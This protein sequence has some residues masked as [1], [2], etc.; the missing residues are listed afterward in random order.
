[1]GPYLTARALT[2]FNA[3]MPRE[4]PDA[5]VVPTNLTKTDPS[6]FLPVNTPVQDGEEMTLL[7]IKCKFFTKYG[8]DDKVHTTVSP[9]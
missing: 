4:G 5:Y 6:A 8:S 2:Q 3:Y 7:G 9:G 1:M